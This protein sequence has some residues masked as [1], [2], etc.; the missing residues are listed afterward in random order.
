MGRSRRILGFVLPSLA[1]LS[2]AAVITG[3][4]EGLFHTTGPLHAMAAAGFV[5]LLALP[6]GLAAALVLRGLWRGWQP[7]QL[8][9]GLVTETGGAPRLA[10]WL[11]YGVVA[12]WLVAAI[13]FN[14]VRVLLAMTR[15]PEVVA[16]SAAMVITAAAV[17]LLFGSR[18]A[19]RVLAH[20]LAALDRRLHRRF[21]R[22]LMTPRLVA[23]GTAGFA[24]L[25]V[26]VLWFVSVRPR[27]GELDV[28]FIHYLLLFV[29]V[30]AGF[31]A[32][33]PLARRRRLAAAAAA[34]LPIAA[35]VAAGA[36]AIWVRY[37][38][39]YTMLEIWGDS[40]LAGGAID[41]LYDVQGMRGE[42]DLAEVRPTEKPGAA[43]P[44]IILITID[45]VRA[46][47]TPP[48]GG[49]ARMP[50]LD[51][52][53]SEGALLEW[54]FSPGNVT[55]R[56]LPSLVLGVGPRRVHGRVAG[57]ALRL[58]PR[59]VT[60]AERLR[61]A[62]Y[63]TAGFFCC[64]SQFGLRHRLG[65]SRGIDH[66]EIEQSGG[67]EL[68]SRAA[69]WLRQ[70][71]AGGKPLFVWLHFIE[72]HRWDIDYTQRDHGG[73]P[74]NR[75]DMALEAVDEM[76]GTVTEVAFAEPRH[77]G[78]IV[79]VTSDHGEGLGERGARFHST[80]LYNSQIRVPLIVAG[81]GIPVRRIQ[82]AVGL[83]GLAPT[84]L[85]LAGYQ[86]PGLPQ[87]D[88]V[89]FAPLLRGEVPDRREDGMAYSA[90]VHDR[91]VAR[92]MRAV[93]I[94]THKLIEF[95]GG[96]RYELYDLARDRN[97]RRDLAERDPA[98]LQQLIGRLDQLDRV[99]HESPF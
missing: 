70:R 89:S 51:K 23:A 96:K 80:N 40:Q 19:V 48:Y 90:M 91:S 16:L 92:A 32:L 63:E 26:V 2:A 53:A 25:V 35:A 68:A 95:D 7:G 14:G 36:L 31:H 67:A 44:D 71:P 64:D 93:V 6:V 55:R 47:H 73:S 83:T 66:M 87:M 58:D 13:A 3:L 10:A 18:P 45:T 99:D 15:T 4:I 94:G 86:P 52:L 62:G 85:D 79:V 28:G 38:R 82:Q 21:G 5:T 8:A 74:S 41:R 50:V 17:V 88:G 57:W 72:P 9:A 29:A 1:G 65:L 37:Q 39:P 49:T 60:L 34:G 43:H 77:A 54:A 42:L 61:A 69:E 81:A 76:L 30:A 98:L 46:D 59:H 24:L 27:V 56:S 75:Y 33:W 12:V 78:T 11:T 20:G 22:S 84:L 97:E